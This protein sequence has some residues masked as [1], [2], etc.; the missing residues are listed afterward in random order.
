MLK[1]RD[2][3]FKYGK[4]EVLKG[5][6][7]DFKGKIALVG[8]NGSGKTTILNILS[9]NIFPKD[10]EIFFKNKSILGKEEFKKNLG[11]MVQEANLDL[12]KKIFDEMRLFANLNNIKDK[13]SIEK[14]LADHGFQS[15]ERIKTLP[16]G[17]YKILLILQ[18]LINNPQYVLLDE[19]FSGLDIINRKIVEEI[20]RKYKGNLIITSHLLDEVKSICSEIIFLKDGIIKKKEKISK[21]KNLNKYY[22]KLYSEGK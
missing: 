2:L 8:P 22:I 16:H 10:G 12:D 6:S 21:I 7:F 19:P 5:V 13:S 14:T 11:V 17:R 1:V 15:N 4:K 9:Q 3:H 18:A 20:L